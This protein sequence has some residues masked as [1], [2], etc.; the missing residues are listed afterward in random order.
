MPTHVSELPDSRWQLIQK[1]FT[2]QRHCPHSAR[3]M[4]EALLWLV[5]TGS[6]WRALPACFPPWPSVYYRFRRWQAQ[7]LWPRLL[8]H[9]VEL[10]RQRQ[11]A[12]VQT[13]Y[14]LLDS[15]SIKTAPFVKE[16]VGFDA[17]K[18]IKGRKRH[19]LTD[20]LGLPVA[21]R[22]DS[23]QRGDSK[24]AEPLLTALA[25]VSPQRPPILVDQVYPH[26]FVSW[27]A[28]HHHWPVEVVA[29]P[30]GVK[31]FVVQPRRWR[32]E[33]SFGWLNFFRR[34]AK[35]YEKTV[36]CSQAMLQLAFIQLLLNRCPT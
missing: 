36:I 7:G 5:R 23:A 12:P 2:S 16:S 27:A 26:T 28:D 3:R 17:H 13:A 1:M 32:I 18:R 20:D 33:R 31:H 9:L 35:D 14:L 8:A 25:H 34:L 19:L 30:A 4:L 29:K 21:L 15:Q 6:P 24:A 22:I 10:E 11:G